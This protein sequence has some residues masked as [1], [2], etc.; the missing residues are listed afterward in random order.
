MNTE[1]YQN[2]IATCIISL[3]PCCAVVVYYYYN[4]KPIPNNDR[5][6]YVSH[7]FGTDKFCHTV[8][9]LKSASYVKEDLFHIL[10]RFIFVRFLEILFIINSF[11]KYM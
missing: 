5:D 10:E 11:F 8:N 7:L 2:K 3:F 4:N 9:M 1:A 6:M